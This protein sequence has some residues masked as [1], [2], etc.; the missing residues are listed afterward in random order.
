MNEHEESGRNKHIL[1]TNGAKFAPIG[2]ERQV[3]ETGARPSTSGAEK[4][5]HKLLK[6]KRLL[7]FR[8]D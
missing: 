4:T 5:H 3:G 1:A 8:F 7:V 6:R 2:A